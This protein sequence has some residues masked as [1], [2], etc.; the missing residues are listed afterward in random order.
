MSI[1]QVYAG[2]RHEHEQYYNEEDETLLVN[3]YGK[4]FIAAWE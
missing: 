3:S 1:D 2:I 4:G